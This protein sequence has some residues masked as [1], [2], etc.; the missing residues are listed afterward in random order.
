MEDLS[1]P[2]VLHQRREVLSTLDNLARMIGIDDIT[3]KIITVGNKCDVATVTQN[4]N[5][6]VSA[7]T[8]KG[9]ITTIELFINRL[10]VKKSITI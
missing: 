1:N 5:L 7:K 8:E 4:E 2:D 10:I 6:Q 3:K 9:K